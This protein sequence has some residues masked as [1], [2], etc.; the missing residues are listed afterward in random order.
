MP[1]KNK[2]RKNSK[3]RDITK[4]KRELIFKECLQEYV[5][6]TKML[7]DRRIIVKLPSG[8]EKMAIIPGRFRKRCYMRV[9]DILLAS[10]RE[11]QTEKLDIIHKYNRDEIS[12][13]INYGE[14]P[15]SFGQT[16]DDIELDGI[17]FDETI[18]IDEI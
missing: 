1:K 8:V 3:N 15:N 12:N 4:S 6:M 2:S 14:I 5:Q 13:L 16:S 7:G 9:G 17:V 10:Y 18:C 11:F